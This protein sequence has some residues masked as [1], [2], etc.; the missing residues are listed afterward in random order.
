MPSALADCNGVVGA[1]R[2]IVWPPLKPGA[3]KSVFS[4]GREAR[5]GAKAARLMRKRVKKRNS[6]RLW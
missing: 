4:E 2:N 1:Q 5:R 6:A 3:A